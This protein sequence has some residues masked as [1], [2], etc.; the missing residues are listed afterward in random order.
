MNER[1][2]LLLALTQVENIAKLVE[3]NDWE[4]FLSSHLFPLKIEFERQLSCIN[5]REKSV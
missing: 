5:A 4:R 2:K 3:G 1:T